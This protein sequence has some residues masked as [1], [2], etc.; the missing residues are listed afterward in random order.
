MVNGE[1]SD[2]LPVDT[3]V[4]GDRRRSQSGSSESKKDGE[5]AAPSEQVRSHT[6]ALPSAF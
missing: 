5:G 2:C 3:A 1:R 4:S 6:P